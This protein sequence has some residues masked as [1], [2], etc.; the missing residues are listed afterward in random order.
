MNLITKNPGTTILSGVSFADYQAIEAVNNSALIALDEDC[1]GCP[2]KAKYQL[3]RGKD[4]LGEDDGATPDMQ[5]G[6]LYH[7]YILEPDDFHKRNVVMDD[8]ISAGII[9]QAIASGSK[10]NAT[11]HRDTG[12]A[13][14]KAYK[15]FVE[16]M[17]QA[18]KNIL[19]ER[20]ISKMAGMQAALMDDADI[21]A[22]FEA[23]RDTEL[24]VLFGYPVGGGEFIQCKARLDMVT[25]G[26]IV[27]LKTA[28]EVSPVRFAKA[29]R[30]Y[31]YDKQAAFYLRAAQSAGLDVESFAFLAQEKKAPYLAALHVMPSD[32]LAFAAKEVAANVY[33]MADHIRR[34]SWPSYGMSELMPPSWVEDLILTEE[35]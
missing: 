21:A 18:G 28:R 7:S 26:R 27:D 2:A 12:F 6:S 30:G 9:E 23:K 4:D 16:A 3:K 24:T 10:T 17:R 8:A 15:D 11:S 33:R 19:S 5:F 22:H 14:L 32:W 20:E 13:N 29:A 31:G 34:G 25:D 35:G 1:G